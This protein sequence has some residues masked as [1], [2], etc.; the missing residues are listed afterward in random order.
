MR[1]DSEE[2]CKIW[3]GIEWSVQN[4][5]E[6]FDEFWPLALQNHENLHFN[7]LLL[8]KLYVWAKKSIGELCLME[9]NIDA[10]FDGKLTCSFKNE[11]TNL[12]NFHHRMLRNLKIGT[13]RRSFYSKRKV[14]ELE[15]CRE[16]LRHGSEEWCKIWRGIECSVQNWQEEFD[17]FWPLAPRNHKSLHFNRLLLNNVYNVCAKKG[18][19][20]LCLMALN[21]DATFKRKLSC[22]FKIDMRNSEIF[23]RARLRA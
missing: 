7:G 5:H 6:E 23:T 13:L 9:L 20:E 19:V 4:W 14:F 21:I 17:K 1:H 15:T 18:I 8:N 11:R 2:W 3:R 16:V 12:T 22:A 10:T